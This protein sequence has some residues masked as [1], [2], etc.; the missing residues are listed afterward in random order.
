MTGAWRRSW[1]MVGGAAGL[2]LLWVAYAHRSAGVS[3]PP[4]ATRPTSDARPSG[5]GSDRTSPVG[6]EHLGHPLESSGEESPPAPP[7]VEDW[8]QFAVGTWEMCRLQGTSGGL[9]QMNEELRRQ[10]VA[11][12]DPATRELAENLLELTAEYDD[13]LDVRVCHAVF[14]E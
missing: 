8:V 11:H 3:P 6:Q 14:A 7:G 13:D 2:G 10:A 4:L 12:P 1:V 5:P 9:I